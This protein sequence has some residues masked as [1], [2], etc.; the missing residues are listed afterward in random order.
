VEQTTQ[1]YR[2]IRATPEEV[3]QAFLNPA[4]LEVWQAPGDMKAKVHHFDLRVDGG[5]QMSLRY[6]Q[7]Q[8]QMKGKT[9]E[10]EDRYTARF[11]EL[12]PSRRIV[13]AIRF[14]TTDPDFDGEMMMEVVCAPIENGTRVTISFQ[15]IPRGIKPTD[16]EAGTASSLAKLAQYVESRTSAAGNVQRRAKVD[17]ARQAITYL[18]ANTKTPG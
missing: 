15:N 18:N 1:N 5:Y 16:N 6:P 17:S 7:S 11:V 13:E 14:D 4:A 9:T 3:Y 2:D 10:R 8:P 12:V